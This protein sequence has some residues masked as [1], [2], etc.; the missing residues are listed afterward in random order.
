MQI[1]FKGRLGQDPTF[2]N[3]RQGGNEFVTLSVAYNQ[4]SFDQSSNQWVT[5][6]VEW[7]NVVCYKPNIVERCKALAKGCEVVIIGDCSFKDYIDKNGIQKVSKNITA[8]D[9]FYTVTGRNAILKS[10]EAVNDL[11]N[12]YS[13]GNGQGYNNNQGF[14]NQNQGF[15]NQGFNN[16]QNQSFNNQGQGFNNSIQ[17]SSNYNSGF[18]Q[19]QGFSNQ[20]QVGS[21]QSQG[22]SNNSGYNNNNGFTQN[23]NN[24]IQT[25]INNQGQGF[26]P[27]PGFSNQPN[28]F[29][30]VGS[31][32]DLRKGLEEL[33]D[34]YS[35]AHITT[36]NEVA[37][38]PTSASNPYEPTP[39]QPQSRHVNNGARVAN[40][41][42]SGRSDEQT[43]IPDDDMPF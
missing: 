25:S 12:Q 4:V 17:T 33:K 9:I 7:Y 28:G 40:D 30:N 3:S 16:N 31:D 2:Y 10:I 34:K 13:N 14:K 29:N 19:N 26:N 18:N 36:T 38:A 20:Q 41:F 35:G 22:F 42:S 27:N 6:F 32:Y 15:N 23:Q 1:I 8:S 24:N 43:S 5:E 21:S 37:K 11:L 39:P